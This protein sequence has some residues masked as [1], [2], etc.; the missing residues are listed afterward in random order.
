M[1][2]QQIIEYYVVRDFSKKLNV[3]FEFLRQNFSSLGKALLFIS[4]APILIGSLIFGVIYSKLIGN[5]VESTATGLT[6]DFSIFGLLFGGGLVMFIALLLGGVITVSTVMAHF[7]LY[8]E[9]QSPDIEVSEVWERTKKL[10]GNM[11][12]M[13]LLLG[14]TFVVVYV[15]V[16]LPVFFLGVFMGPLI[17]FVLLAIYAGL[18]YLGI[19]LT[20]VFPIG[21]FENET[22]F[23]AVSKAFKLIKDNWWKTFGFHLILELIRSSMAG[24]FFIPAYLLMIFNIVHTLDGNPSAPSITMQLLMTSFFAIFIIV[25]FLGYSITLTGINFQYFNL[26]ELKESRGLM[27]KLE[28][29]GTQETTSSEEEH[30]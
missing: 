12:G 10:F 1:Q 4:G 26:V 22:Y 14:L 18:I 21:A 11:L 23:N 17:L 3:T 24:I 16:L 9:K 25:N 19:T 20:F 28:N 2:S 6:P 30:Y 5:I 13:T 27:A 7:Q 8:Q 29:L 15:L